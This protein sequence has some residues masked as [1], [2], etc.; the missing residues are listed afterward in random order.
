M[1]ALDFERQRRRFFSL[2]VAPSLAVLCVITLAP[3]VYLLLTSLTPLD[4]TRPETAWNFGDPLRN[5]VLL[6]EDGRLHNSVWV[7]AKLSFWTVTLQIL[8]GLGFA[9]LLNARSRFLEALRTVFLIPMVLPPIVVAIIWKVIY[10]PDISPMHWFFREVGWRVPALITDPSLA[11]IA[12]IV[13]DTWEW[14]PFTMLMTLAALQMLPQELVDAAKVDGAT[15]WQSTIH[16][17]LPFLRGVLLV[18]GLFRLID[19][20]KAF[21]LIF[22]LTEGGPGSV[23]EVTNYYSFLQAFNFSFLGYS[24]AIT[25]VLLAATVALSWLIVRM[26]GWGARV[27]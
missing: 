15:P 19:S 3:A 10:T 6:A 4:L 17:T 7:Q 16:V 13:A 20:L 5:F 22:I 9:L 25:V 14:F 11:L 24:S 2:C 8:I 23:T 1:T 18:A 12:I 27:D 26:V 21:P